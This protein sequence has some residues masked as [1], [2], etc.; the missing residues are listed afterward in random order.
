MGDLVR[1]RM[2]VPDRIGL[3]SASVGMSLFAFD[4]VIASQC[5]SRRTAEAVCHGYGV[6]C[7]ESLL[8]S[9]K[10]WMDAMGELRRVGVVLMDA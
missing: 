10:V 2:T 9:L 7:L 8:E 1:A 3:P 4:G 6:D 5:S